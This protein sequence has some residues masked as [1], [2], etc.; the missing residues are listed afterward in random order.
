MGIVADSELRTNWKNGGTTS[1]RSG[2]QIGK[3][4]TP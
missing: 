2:L 4:I 1:Y 3:M